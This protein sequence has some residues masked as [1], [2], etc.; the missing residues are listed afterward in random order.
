VRHA[1]P[2]LI[3]AFLAVSTSGFSQNRCPDSGGGDCP[4]RYLGRLSANPYAPDSTGNPFGRYGSRY[5]PDGVNNPYSRTGRS[6]SNPF[7]TDAPIV[8]GEGGRYLGKLSANPYDP[9]STSN[10]FGRY[11]SKHS[12]DSVNNPYG[13]YGNSFSP[14]SVS[15]PYATKAPRIFE[16]A[17]GPPTL[18]QP[19]MQDWSPYRFDR[20]D[21]K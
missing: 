2:T 5:A 11:G 21:R 4:G 17:A 13:K 18:T 3:A 12:P 9:D 15:N 19:G 7:A 1:L 6:V 16:P 10:P 20:R 14:Y 8:V